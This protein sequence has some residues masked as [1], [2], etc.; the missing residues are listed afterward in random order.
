MADEASSKTQK[1]AKKA[2]N[3]ADT[4]LQGKVSYLPDIHRLLPQSPDAEQGI[5]ASLL[6]APRDVGGMC[7]EKGLL[8]ANFHIPSHSTI[9]AELLDMWDKNAPIDVITLCQRLRDKNLL[10]SCGGPAFVTQLFTF[11]PTA[12]NAAYYLEIVQEK[13]TLREIIRV[14]TEYAARSYDEQHD[15]HILLDEVETRIFEIAKERFKDK[16]ASLK[17]QLMTAITQIDEMYHRRGQITGLATGL[18]DFDKMTDGLHGAEMIVIAARPSMGKCLSADSEIVLADGSVATIGEIFRRKQARLLTLGDDWRLRLTEPSAFVDD[19]EKPVFRVTTRLGRTVEATAPHP[20]LTATGWKHLHDL[21]AGEQVAVPRRMEIFGNA[22][23]RDCEVKLLAYLL[24]DGGLTDTTPESASKAGTPARSAS[25]PSRASLRTG[26]S[27]LPRQPEFTNTSAR[28][29]DEFAECAAQFG[30]LSV[31]R[32][33]SRLRA[34]T[35]SVSGNRAGIAVERAAF[36]ERLSELLATRG[37]SRRQF[38]LTA[39]VLPSSLTQWAAGQC[40]PCEPHLAK[41]CGALGVSRE[42]LLPDEH[43]VSRRNERNR[44]TRWLNA[45]GLM[46]RKAAEKFIPDFIFRLPREQLAVFLNRLFATDGWACVLRTGQGQIGFSS[47]SERMIR[48]VQH[49]LLRFGI[50]AS[51]RRRAML[52]RKTRR[53][54]WQ[55]DITDARAMRTFVRDIGIF[56]KEPAVDAVRAAVESKHFQTNTDLLPLEIWDKVREAKGS[57]SWPS[58]A[59]RAGLKG[60][61]NIH[62]GRRRLTRDR[63]AALARA[64]GNRKLA[65]LAESDVYWDKIVSIEPLG[66]KQVYDLTIPE[67]HNFIA[68]D[69]CVHNTALAMN[70]AEHIA[71]ELQKPIAVFSLEMSSQQLVQRLL[72]SRAK[73]NLGR[74]RD[75]FL[76]ERDF[77]ALTA[78]ASK[79]STAQIFIDDTAGISIL[80]LRAKARRLKSQHDIQAI[81]IDYLQLLRSTTRRAQDNRQ[82]EIAEISSGLKALA[83]ELNLPIVVLAQLN[84]NPESRTGDSKGRPRLSDLRESGSIEQDADL[85]GL[86]VREEYYADTDEDKKAAEGKATLI[87]AKQRNGPVGDVKLTFLKEFT[88]FETRA[89]EAHEEE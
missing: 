71:V 70:I 67:T 88:R 68:N 74:V 86:L 73:V 50:V 36:G 84:R 89:E 25:G 62:V 2:G 3:R 8:P 63:L 79:L 83:K 39:G 38:A 30:G 41:L 28:L 26:V 61:T 66:P 49:L 35:L 40:V 58:L 47:T 10:E 77:P 57:E 65:A 46:G 19:G 81:F 37:Q 53:P 87:I 85:V 11:L 5:L 75:G 6:L 4:D 59:R 69:I 15:V 1:P 76:S 20:F 51:L 29:R 82:L 32:S 54:A 27:A 22:H 48:Q 18:S 16:S 72:C 9:Y 78:A 80:E 42:R 31:S 52:Y 45:L 33:T 13:Y 12:A 34:P 14:C 64:L 24:G 17:D 7:A 55:L 43:K 21:R 60:W 23:A 56:G 44:L